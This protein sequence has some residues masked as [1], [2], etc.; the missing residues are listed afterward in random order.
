MKS[1]RIALMENKGGRKGML[2]AITFIVPHAFGEHHSCGKWCKFHENPAAY[3]RKHL[4]EGK[5]LQGN[6]L[7]A[8]LTESIQGFCTK[9]M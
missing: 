5:S 8:F 7:R 2:L 1:F 4:P 6:G 3:R 9:N